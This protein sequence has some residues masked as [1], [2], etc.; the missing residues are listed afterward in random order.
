MSDE[1]II[2]L[3]EIVEEVNVEIQEAADGQP[4]TTE[5]EGIQ[6][7]PTVFPPADHTH[8]AADLDDVVLSEVTLPVITSPA[9]VAPFDDQDVRV[10]IL[11][12]GSTEPYQITAP[13]VPLVPPGNPFGFAGPFIVHN[14]AAV[15]SDVFGQ[16]IPANATAYIRW[17]SGGWIVTFTPATTGTVAL[18]AD[19][20]TH[21]AATDPHGDRAYVDIQL[22]DKIVL[23]GNAGTPSNIVLT[24][25]TGLP[26][27]TGV[28]G[29]ASGMAAF[30]ATPTSDNLA[31]AITDGTG[32]GGSLM[33]NENPSV[34]SITVNGT[35]TMN[36][37]SYVYSLSTRTAHNA[38]LGTTTEVLAADLTTS[39]AGGHHIFTGLPVVSGKTYRISSYIRVSGTA[40]SVHNGQFTS[41]FNL[42]SDDATVI[43]AR[44][45]F[46]TSNV[47]LGST[48]WNSFG[49]FNSTGTS[50]QTASLDG[51]IRPS[52]S[53]LLRFIIYNTGSG[54]MTAKRGSY[55]A[56]QLLD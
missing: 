44:P 47:V 45:G 22:A 46:E 8:D 19:I 30:L 11:P 55:I 16:I 32:E 9:S 35:V 23:N 5:W 20:A 13:T 50:S 17:K 1:V 37:T 49:W 56:L 2:D 25:G 12:Y 53:G 6:D 24:N 26:I 7:K 39:G 15:T 4:G 18:T 48:P 27:S 28:S 3:T 52:S 21:A 42:L 38:A 34:E 31:A 43:Y 14:R 36:A 10:V 54:T 29:L 51:T 41:T 40:G 33:F